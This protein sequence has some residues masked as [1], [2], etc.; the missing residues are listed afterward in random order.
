MKK[1]KG[2]IITAMFLASLF[3]AIA[4][5]Y[6]Q[7]HVHNINTGEDFVTVQNAIDDAD[8]Q[9][10]HTI[11][12]DAVTLTEW[13]IDVDKDL[14]IKGAGSGLTVIDG[15]AHDSVF[16]ISIGT[17]VT[18]LDMTIKDGNSDS[19]YGGG[20]YN[21]GTL[22][23]TNC[24]VSGNTCDYEGGGI[25]NDGT[26]T[27]TNCTVS[28][29]Y[30]DD[31]GGGIL[32]YNG[33]TLTIKNSIISENEAD[34]D[35]GGIEN[36]GHLTIENCTIR[37]N[38]AYNSSD[39]G[40]G[41]LDNYA[42]GATLTIVNSTV[43]GNTSYYWGGGVLNDDGAT[44]KIE[45][46]TIS[47][48]YADYDGGGIYND[49]SLSSTNEVKNTII[50]NNSCGDDGP[51]F[52]GTL[53]SYGYNLIGDTTDCTITEA[54]NPGT[55]ITGVDPMLGLLQNNGGSTETHALLFGSPAINVASC[56]DID[57]DPVATDQRGVSRPQGAGCDW[58]L[59]VCTSGI[60]KRSTSLLACSS[61][62]F[63]TGEHMS[64][65]HRRELT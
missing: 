35:G 55:N 20:I 51:D 12:I 52:Y 61:L 63:E 39:Y 59:R 54:A 44:L 8:T 65:M 10:G 26:L 29:N 4:P 7:N 36:W 33:A 62:P 56:T 60:C 42:S 17:T 34:E 46:C 30:A 5:V 9:D 21:S 37:G 3:A 18:I 16:V 48:N 41:G 64:W 40:G 11:T 45:N 19:G 31:Y 27:M 49:D 50:A 15:D 43:S 2:G 47:D 53:T 58:G 1:W 6:A 38:T 13:D 28:D 32:N 22:T 14:T 57:D 23:M 25:Y 24:T